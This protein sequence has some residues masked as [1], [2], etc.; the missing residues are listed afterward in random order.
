[1]RAHRTR[2]RRGAPARPR[3]GELVEELAEA[4]ALDAVRLH[5]QHVAEARSRPALLAALA[6]AALAALAAA[7]QLHPLSLCTLVR[8]HRDRSPP[9]PLKRRRPRWSAAEVD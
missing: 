5:A 4:R 2:A 8:V 1:M 7:A 3:R 9:T 6:L